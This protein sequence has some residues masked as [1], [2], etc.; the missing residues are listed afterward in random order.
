MGLALVPRIDDVASTTA[1]DFAIRFDNVT[2][3]QNG[4]A[5][6][7]SRERVGWQARQGRMC[8]APSWSAQADH[9]RAAVLNS[10]NRGW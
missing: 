9:P 4:V 2:F 10:R 7:I 6:P 3:K 8:Y 5:G 1:I